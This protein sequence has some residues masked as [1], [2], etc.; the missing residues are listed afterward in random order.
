M[1][2]NA[3]RRFTRVEIVTIRPIPA[4]SA[5]ATIASRSS[6]KSGKSRWQWLSTSMS[7]GCRWL[8]IAREHRRRRG[9]GDAGLDADRAAQ[10][11]KIA[12]VLRYPKA[13][14][15]LCGGG[16]HRRLRK[17]GDLSDHLCGHVKHRALT[18]R[19]GLRKCPWRFAGK[20]AIGFGNH[21]P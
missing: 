12:L 15:Q 11:G 5:R 14:E 17:D 9:E 16:R 3:W 20:I 2:S 8:D 10:R 18:D 19:I 13:V 6:A 7:L 4:A 21:G 1:S